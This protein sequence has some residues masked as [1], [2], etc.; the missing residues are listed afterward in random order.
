MNVLR[1]VAM[2][3]QLIIFGIA[4]A[5]GIFGIIPWWAA[6]I[7]GILSFVLN[8]YIALGVLRLILGP[9]RF[10]ELVAKAQ[11]EELNRRNK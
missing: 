10:A 5:L 11:L 6:I 9:E 1:V 7:L 4:I 3:V 2:V 8:G